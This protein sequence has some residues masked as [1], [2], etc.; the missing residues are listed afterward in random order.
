[1]ELVGAASAAPTHANQVDDADKTALTH[2][3]HQ[4]AAACRGLRVHNPQETPHLVG[5]IQLCAQLLT[6]KTLKLL[7]KFKL[8]NCVWA[9][10]VQ[11]LIQLNKPIG[12][13]GGGTAN[14]QSPAGGGQ[15]SVRIA[16]RRFV[17]SELRPDSAAPAKANEHEVSVELS[18]LALEALG[19]PLSPR[20][21]LTGP[22]Q[23]P[24]CGQF[25][26]SAHLSSP[27][28]TQPNE[29]VRLQWS[30]ERIGLIASGSNSSSSAS[31]DAANSLRLAGQQPAGGPGGM[32]P[33]LQT[34]SSTNLNQ[35]ELAE[36]QWQTLKRWVASQTGSSLIVDAQL[37]QFVPQHY[38]FHL[39]VSFTTSLASFVLNATHRVGRLDFDAPI[40]TIY[41]THLLANDQQLNANSQLA[42]M[43]DIQVPAC[44][45]NIKQV[46]LYWQVSDPR[47]RF[48]QTYAPVYLAKSGALPEQ[49]LIEFRLNLFYGIRLKKF[50]SAS[51]V[52]PTGESVLDALISDG[53]LMASVSQPQDLVSSQANGNSNNNDG[54]QQQL[55]LYAISQEQDSRQQQDKYSY[56][57]S[58]FDGRTAQPCYKSL[59]L[60]ASSGGTRYDL[61][62]AGQ[63]VAALARPHEPA[64]LGGTGL[65]PGQPAGAGASNLLLVDKTRQRQPILRLPLGWLE[66]DA[67]L[68]FGLQRFDRQNPSQHSK[69]EY[70]LISVQ[71]VASAHRSGALQVSVGP[72]LVG[73]ARQRA[74][75]RNPLTGAMLVMANAP[76]V[77]VGRASPA[78]QVG[79]FA[80]RLPNYLHP[81]HWTSRT[82]TDS[83]SQ[84]EELVTELHLSQEMLLAHG[85]HQV[86]L[87]VC[88]RDT[89][90]Q[91]T[92]TI[93]LDV[94]QGVS[95]CRV[96]LAAGQPAPADS[97]V[98]P[99]GQAG[100]AV[101]Q[102][103]SAGG[104]PPIVVAVNYCNIPLGVSPLTY[105]LYIIDSS[106]SDGFIDGAN[107]QQQPPGD[108]RQQ[109]DDDYMNEADELYYEELAQPLS[110]PQL[111]PVFVLAGLDALA[112]VA[113]VQ[114]P[115]SGG[116]SSGESAPTPPVRIRFGARVCDRLQ[117][118][119]MFYSSP[120]D[121]LGLAPPTGAAAAAEQSSRLE[122]Q[123]SQQPRQQA[124]LRQ[125]NG[126]GADAVATLNGMLEA[127]KRANT[128]GNSIAAISIVNALITLGQRLLRQSGGRRRETASAV[129]Y[130]NEPATPSA[131]AQHD[132]DRQTVAG[133]GQQQQLSADQIERLRDLLQV[134]MRDC[135]HYGAQSGQRQLHYTE[136]GQANL[137]LAAMS[138]ILAS[139]QAGFELRARALR[140]MALLVRKSIDNQHSS[141]AP[142][143]LQSVPDLKTIQL[144]YESLFSAFSQHTTTTAAATTTSG[145]PVG[146]RPA[147][148]ADA[149]TTETE[150]REIGAHYNNNH[151]RHRAMRRDLRTDLNDHHHHPHHHHRHP[152][153]HHQ[154]QQRERRQTQPPQ[155]NRLDDNKILSRPPIS[156]GRSNSS[157]VEPTWPG[158]SHEHHHQADSADSTATAASDPAA[159][160]A[161]ASTIASAAIQPPQHS[162]SL[163]ANRRNK[164]EAVLAYLRLVRQTHRTLL[165]AIALQIPLGGVQQLEYQS[166]GSP[167]PALQSA[168]S[169]N[170]N[171]NL[172]A[173]AAVNRFLLAPQ[174]PA[175]IVSSL[176]RQTDLLSGAID[177]DLRDF[178]SISVSFGADSGGE[179]ALAKLGRHMRQSRIRCRN[180]T[181][182]KC[183]SFVLALTSFAGKA[184]FRSL[185]VAAVARDG[186]NRDNN[187]GAQQLR[188]PIIQLDWLSPVDGSNLIE[189]LDD[190]GGGKRANDDDAPLFKSD[191]RATV[192]FTLPPLQQ[193]QVVA[194]QATTA[195]NVT[196]NDHESLGAA[197]SGQQAG[198]ANNVA[199]S[200]GDN[201]YKCYK[202]DEASNEWVALSEASHERA[203]PD[204]QSGGGEP[205]HRLRCSFDGFGVVGV[206][207]GRPP[208]VETSTELSIALG[209]A[210]VLAI[211]TV[212]SLLGCMA[213]KTQTKQHRRHHESNLDTSTNDSSKTSEDSY[214]SYPD[215]HDDRQRRAQQH[216]PPPAHL[217]HTLAFR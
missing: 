110:A 139:P 202:F 117:S 205:A 204:E 10:Q 18:K 193:Q 77:I 44:A 55:V 150:T 216:R 188:V 32:P 191:F 43:A 99:A 65:Q 161:A 118:C 80:W 52:V 11:F 182:T 169:P 152:H 157:S 176:T 130:S 142:A 112:L 124:L 90:A 116:G 132:N 190:G 137:A 175:Y 81:L 51:S 115:Q 158:A 148:A 2:R 119:R 210:C 14:D 35:A 79:S 45:R 181:L 162:T 57:W 146:Q 5:G 1:L 69:T 66:S 36:L 163:K 21:A 208:A 144:A 127:A 111:S 97:V 201:N 86:Q 134:A 123:N 198:K 207:Q 8:H 143:T 121:P 95:Q 85:Q 73:R 186:N 199:A 78:E 71:P 17:L 104:G 135:L 167:A 13:G 212:F 93:S 195:T 19:M 171:N 180:D 39:S 38:E 83:L 48:E 149:A 59:K 20:L 105:Q 155:R 133:G 24:P 68:W 131:A 12:G 88:S 91:S 23:V 31:A 200:G 106:S 54:Q 40:G 185:D 109:A 58:C 215:E 125:T 15:S 84:R 100:A 98:P 211:V 53:L 120:I 156:R 26:I 63:Q 126:H 122:A 129:V 178:G 113:L 151:D 6:R 154:Q 89:G 34:T 76:A 213:S 92:A 22:N 203:S 28:G 49:A 4:S 187:N 147:A 47:V 101:P 165:Q 75:I 16:F 194:A 184:P 7:H 102:P 96:E 136:S 103:M 60:Q 64:P 177:V 159:A 94:V 74:T 56:Q 46:G 72:V 29:S 42:L 174:P 140:L 9:S 173:A 179:G 107:K 138:R 87:V 141:Q 50:A 172:A 160:A 61:G 114:A 37:M 217:E 196:A 145:A 209:V 108:E 206:F 166:A 41:G 153:H 214:D 82:A 128:A 25:S 67:Q 33:P 183:S 70:A 62:S 197:E 170:N 164:E 3:R 27:Y 168:P 189:L 30:V 192:T